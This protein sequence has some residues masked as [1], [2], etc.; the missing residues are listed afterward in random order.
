MD[1]G[2]SP[3]ATTETPD[4]PTRCSSPPESMANRMVS[5]VLLHRSTAWT[6]TKN[7]EHDFS[8]VLCHAVESGTRKRSL[9]QRQQ[10]ADEEIPFHR[11]SGSTP[12]APSKTIMDTGRKTPRRSFAIR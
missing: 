7:E 1:S 10:G 11:R 5:S 4:R 3:S 6:A 9:N 12:G 8:P 2:Q